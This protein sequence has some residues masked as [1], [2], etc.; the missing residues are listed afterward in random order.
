MPTSTAGARRLVGSTASAAGPV[1]AAGRGKGEHNLHLTLGD[2]VCQPWGVVTHVVVTKAGEHTAYA[3]DPKTATG[4]P[5]SK[6]NWW[7]LQGIAK[8]AE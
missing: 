2:G 4:I 1:R 3:G 6:E 5:I 8:K 7:A